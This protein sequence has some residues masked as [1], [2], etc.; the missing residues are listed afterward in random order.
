MPR[1]WYDAHRALEIEDEEKRELYL[2]ILADRKPYFMCY[3]YPDLMREYKKYIKT[4][5]KKARR[6]FKKSTEEIFAQPPET[7]TDAERDFVHFHE[8]L[9]PVSNGDCVTN[10]VCRRFEQT[11]DGYIG[12][13]IADRDFD[14]GI[15]KS[16]VTYTKRQYAAVSSLFADFGNRMRD[17]MRRKSKERIKGEEARAIVL[18][19][20][21]TFRSLCDMECPNGKALC[22]IMLDLCYR[23]NQTMSFAWTICGEEILENLLERSGGIVHL[24]VKD[25]GGDVSYNGATYSFV[26]KQYGGLEEDEFDFE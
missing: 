20:Y 24:P 1:E 12:K 14:Y 23:K 22:N 5:D 18:R 8:R 6:D 10:R 16:D 19:L 15:M 11:F 3:I 21:D 9:M 2:S 25:A 26:E 13:H 17:L 4:A 7:L